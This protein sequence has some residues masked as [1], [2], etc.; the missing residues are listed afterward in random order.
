[1][2][3]SLNSLPV[4]SRDF[5]ESLAWIAGPNP[6]GL[7]IPP[8]WFLEELWTFDPLLVMFASQEEPIYR[9]CRR[10]E[11]GSPIHTALV[12]NRKNGKER[13]DTAVIVNHRLIPVTSVLPSPMV[14]WS[15][16]LLHDLARRDIR[17]VGGWRKAADIL[18]GYDDQEEAA[19]RRA[20]EDGAAARARAAWHGSKWTNGETVDLGGR[21]LHGARTGAKGVK[22][23]PVIRPRLAG[24]GPSSA[25]FTGREEPL[26][27]VRP[28]QIE[29]SYTETPDRRTG[30]FHP[31]A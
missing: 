8:K 16:T 10:V 17:R 31:A 29:D 14:A 12:G 18:D 26:Q 4:A 25:I 6:F 28:Y 1:M 15:T 11:H 2:L 20:N 5:N 30:L 22:H 23:Y 21:K 24:A 3:H 7:S 13:P 19:W 27:E 9:L